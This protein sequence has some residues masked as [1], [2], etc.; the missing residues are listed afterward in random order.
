MP[1][2]HVRRGVHRDRQVL[3]QKDNH[4]PGCR[5]QRRIGEAATLAHKL[6]RNPARSRFHLRTLTE[7]AQFDTA[8]TGSDLHPSPGAVQAHTSPGS[9]SLNR[10]AYVAQ[11]EIASTGTCPEITGTL[12]HLNAA[13]PSLNTG[14]LRGTDKHPATTAVHARLPG[15]V[16]NVDVPFSTGE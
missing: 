9:F 2:R 10:A 13:R 7:I 12:A 4:V 16:L 5:M 15:N 3:W 1:R 11:I 14:S 6:S 8:A